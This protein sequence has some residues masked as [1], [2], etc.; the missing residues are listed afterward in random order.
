[1]VDVTTRKVDYAN[2]RKKG[3][4]E[5]VKEVDFWPLQLE[6]M[7]DLLKEFVCENGNNNP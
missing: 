5:M 7:R 4:K 6:T 1:M 3:T 2:P